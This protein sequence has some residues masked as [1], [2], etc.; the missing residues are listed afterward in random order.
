MILVDTHVHI[1]SC[2]KLERFFAA[3]FKNL[4]GTSADRLI[5]YLTERSDLNFYAELLTNKN[6]GEFSIKRSERGLTV[7]SS[8]GRQL[9]I[10]PGRQIIT[11]ERIEVLALDTPEFTPDGGETEVVI[12]QLNDSG[13]FVILPWSFGKW[14]GGRGSVVERLI[15][16]T[17]LKFALGDPGHR[18][19][20]LPEPK[21][22]ALG[23][24]Y[25]RVILRGSDPL[26]LSGDEVRVGSYGMRFSGSELTSD[27]TGVGARV[28]VV[29]SAM[30]QMRLRLG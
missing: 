2:Y 18:A 1:Y 6:V 12:R 8:S 7:I 22:F 27:G 26:P 21:L 4:G 3:A 14:S 24:E 20:E 15:K 11:Q 19:R 10:R 5:L 25:G 17:T 28:G 9:E 13:V 29:E 16:D 23:R 30:L